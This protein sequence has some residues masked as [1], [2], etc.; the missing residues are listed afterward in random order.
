MYV[1][2][3]VDTLHLIILSKNTM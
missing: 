3:A 1:Y 2:F